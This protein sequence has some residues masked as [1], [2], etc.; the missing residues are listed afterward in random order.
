[1]AF[2]GIEQVIGERKAA[3]DALGKN[4]APVR[5]AL[6][7]FQ[8]SVNNSEALSVD[9]TPLRNAVEAAAKG[10]HD[11][12]FQFNALI[13]VMNRHRDPTDTAL[14]TQVPSAITLLGEIDPEGQQ[15][16]VDLRQALQPLVKLLAHPDQLYD[17]IEQQRKTEQQLEKLGSIISQEQLLKFAENLVTNPGQVSYDALVGTMQF[18]GLNR[19][20]GSAL[21]MFTKQQQQVQKGLN[22]VANNNGLPPNPGQGN[23]NPQE[24]GPQT[25]AQLVSVSQGNLNT[26]NGFYQSTLGFTTQMFNAFPRLARIF[27]GEGADA[28]LAAAKFVSSIMGPLGEMLATFNS[29]NRLLNALLPRDLGESLFLRGIVT[30]EAENRNPPIELTLEQRK[31]TRLLLDIVMGTGPD[32]AQKESRLLRCVQKYCKYKREGKPVSTKP[33]FEV[34]EENKEKEYIATIEAEAK[35]A[36]TQPN[37]P[38]SPNNQIP[39][40]VRNSIGNYF[41]S[42]LEKEIIQ[43]ENQNL[44][45]LHARDQMKLK[46]FKTENPLAY[47]VKINDTRFV[48]LETGTSASGQNLRELRIKNETQDNRDPA[49]IRI[50]PD[51]ISGP[52]M[53]LTYVM[54]KLRDNPNAAKIRFPADATDASQIVIPS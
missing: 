36:A 28:N 48:T 51:G 12:H 10:G 41:R 47:K 13:D 46:F 19:T 24:R 35:V 22:E 23:L 54:D 3:I 26:G 32:R 1:M 38:N 18:T 11:L 21:Q 25:P 44:D 45:E 43:T 31:D 8:K 39:E 6:E 30:K 17:H 29:Q 49:N 53:R 16:R 5:T 20:F 15:Q 14:L 9:T 34:T 2:N 42:G 27:G 50:R 33:T 7:E 37:N 4:T 40:V 52:G